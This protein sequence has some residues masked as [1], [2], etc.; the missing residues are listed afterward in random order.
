MFSLY[1][2]SVSG[3]LVCAMLIA[4]LSPVGSLTG[5]ITAVEEQTL[6]SLTE[7]GGYT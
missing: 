2:R 3:I 7:D 4:L 6:T 5:L 1:K